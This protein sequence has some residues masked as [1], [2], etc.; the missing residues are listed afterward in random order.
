MVRGSCLCGEISYTLESDL[1]FL[2]HCH[3]LECRKFSGSSNATNA[4]VVGADLK[5]ADPNNKL[6]S[7]SLQ[8]GARYFCSNCGS[9]IYSTADGGEYP[10]LH[11][12]S[13]NEYPDRQ[14]DANLWTSE[15]CSWTRIDPDV[16]NF[17]KALE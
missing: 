10:S 8:N 16:Q 11:C 15:K 4:T 14:L 3:C 7:F 17:A 6:T 1:L 13:I 12:G 5:I 2:Y 9:P